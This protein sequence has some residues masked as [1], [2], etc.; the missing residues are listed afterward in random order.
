MS[1]I[2]AVK[3]TRDFYPE[4]MAVRNWIIDGWKAASIRN[5]FVEYD[6]PIFEYLELYTRKSGDEIVS[7]LFSMTDRGGRDLAIRPEITP[8]LARM[9]NQQINALPRPVKWFSAPRLCRAERP[10][11]GRLREFFQWNCDIVGSES[12]LA[13]AECIYTAID[14]LRSTGLTASDIVARI[15]SRSML[16]EILLS[17]G[18]VTDEL[19]TIYALLDKMPKVSAED[20]AKMAE[21]QIPNADKRSNLMKLPL[22]KTMDDIQALAS[23]EAAAAAVNELRE[24]FA[25]LDTMGIGEFCKFDIQIVRG[26]AYYTGPVFEIFDRSESL[27]AICGGGRYDS[28]LTILGGPAV[29]ATGFGM[30]DVVLEILLRERGIMPQF[31][32]STDYFVID[33]GEDLFDRALK[34]TCDIRSRGKSASFSYKRQNMKKQFKQADT[35]QAK[36]AVIVGQETLDKNE[37]IVKEL[38]TSEQ[39][40]ISVDDFL[41]SLNNQ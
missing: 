26:L 37:V 12:I 13:D 20:F 30:G 6:S 41:G 27:R 18:F 24:L 28:L 7:Q 34:L 22:V 23:S 32:A 29:P 10:Q 39:K 8:S 4:I 15:S 33:A 5:G 17:M 40:A 9:V 36:Y 25:V 11:K 2:A 14:Y 21:E 16:A 19:N 38:S 1:K 35:Q 3:G 31:T